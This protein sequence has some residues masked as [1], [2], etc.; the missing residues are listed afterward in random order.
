MAPRLAPQRVFVFDLDDT[1]FETPDNYSDAFWEFFCLL[2]GLKRFRNPVV[3]TLATLQES[4]DKSL[5][6]KI[7]PDTGKLYAYTME[8]YPTSFVL[9][10]EELCRRGHGKYQENIARHI[11]VIGMN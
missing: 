4:I 10:Y 11:K 5:I 6:S 1:L 7:N 3:Q 8:R 9:A 2:R